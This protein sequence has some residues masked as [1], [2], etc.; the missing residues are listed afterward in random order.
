MI[1]TVNAFIDA[2]LNYET[3][4]EEAYVAEVTKVMEYGSKINKYKLLE[5]TNTAQTQ[6]RYRQPRSLSTELQG[7]IR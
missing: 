6:Q 5:R 7:G 3:Q 1:T 2:R 4:L